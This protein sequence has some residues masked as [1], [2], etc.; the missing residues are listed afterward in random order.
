MQKQGVHSKLQLQRLVACSPLGGQ[1]L[2]QF[3]DSLAGAWPPA[4][5]SKQGLWASVSQR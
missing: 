1:F 2:H 3:V 5:K 4:L